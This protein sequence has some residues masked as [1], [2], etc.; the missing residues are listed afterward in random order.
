MAKTSPPLSAAAQALPLGKY[1]HSKSGGEYEVLGVARHEATLQE[2][3]VYRSLYGD[4][5]LWARDLDVFTE[6]VELD[7]EKKP[8]FRYVG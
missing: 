1:I 4:H 7:G 6:E 2:L 3:V 5:S 8:R